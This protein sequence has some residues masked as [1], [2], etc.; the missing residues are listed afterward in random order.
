MIE[1]KIIEFKGMPLFQKARFHAHELMQGSFSEFACF[2][3]MV[4][5]KM[6]SY[7]VR[8]LHTIGEKDAIIK[9]CGSYVQQYIPK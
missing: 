8:G 4:Q 7:D 1:T 9:N 3:Y 5:G 6:I 2:F